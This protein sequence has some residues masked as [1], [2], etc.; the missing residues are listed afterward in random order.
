MKKIVVIIFILSFK[1]VN[2]QE[3][4]VFTEPASNRPD[5]SMGVR[6]GY[7]S[8]KM[9]HDNKFSAYRLDPEIIFGVSKKVTLNLN[10]YASNMFQSNL[11]IEG[12]GIGAKYRFFSQDGIH[13]HFRLAIFGKISVINNPT[14][15]NSIGKHEIPD[16]NGGVIVHD[17][18]HTTINS[19]IDIEGTNSG[20]STGV[21]ATK[22]VNKLAVS[23]SI[24]YLYR[25]NNLHNKREV[26]AP[27]RAINYSLSAGYLLFPKEYTSYKQ[28][29][30]NLYTEFL[31]S[32]TWDDKKYFIDIAPAI[33]F[34]IKSIARVDIGYRTQISGNTQRMA[35]SAFLLR[36]EY[37]FLNVFSKK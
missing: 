4:Y 21:I 36:V 32:N 10:G 34:I 19:E 24:G 6:L 11:K 37:N 30:V 7:K 17:I 13:S 14:V 5:K 9:T 1:L 2:A 12:A 29:N 20:L 27:W 22:L 8:F 23:S 15:L 25:L 28:T 18:I 16:G 33:Q 35:N 31:G 3:L 26:I